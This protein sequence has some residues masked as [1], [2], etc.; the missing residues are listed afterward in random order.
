[1]EDNEMKRKL[2]AILMAMS[3]LALTACGGSES[4]TEQP[5]EET[6]E[7][8]GV[9]LEE[10]EEE[11]EVEEEEKVETVYLVASRKWGFV[12]NGVREE[13]ITEIT[14]DERGNEILSV[15]KNEDGSIRSTYSSEYDENGNLT[16]LTMDYEGSISYMEHEY[17]ESGNL[18]KIVESNENGEV[19]STEIYEYDANNKLIKTSKYNADNVLEQVCEYDENETMRKMIFYMDGVVST[20]YEYN[21]KGD[22]ILCKWEMEDFATEETRINEYDGNG[23]LVK[24]LRKYTGLMGEIT[25]N[26]L[27]YEYDEYGNVLNVYQDGQISEQYEYEYDENGNCIYDVWKNGSGDLESFTERE[28]ISMEVP[29]K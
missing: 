9:V 7:L 4:K 6:V 10:T 3:V 14:Y 20:W 29:V 11:L 16:K 27:T 24:T 28:Y 5:V 8:E 23:R 18:S 21:E 26:I 17:D 2:V 12:S 19:T 13:N 25:E 22:E 15:N 1:M